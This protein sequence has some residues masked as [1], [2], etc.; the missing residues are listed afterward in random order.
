MLRQNYWCSHLIVGRD[1]AGAGYYYG[2]FDAQKIFGQI[3]KNSLEIEPLPLDWTFYCYKCGSM[4]SMK[5]CPHEEKAVIDENG[6]YKGGDRLLFFDTMLRKLLSGGKPV[7]EEFSKPEVI[8]ILREYYDSQEEKVEIKLHG[9]A[10][11]E[12]L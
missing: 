9:A 5:T 3:P 8:A 11:G 4:A 7:T 1:H 6:Q 2:P 10:T 12:K